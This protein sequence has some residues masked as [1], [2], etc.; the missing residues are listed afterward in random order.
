M[1]YKTE[2]EKFWAGEFGNE[3]AERNKA[4]QGVI[5]NIALF[6]E[7]LKRTS[8]IRTVLEFGPNIGRNIKALKTLFPDAK[9][10]AVEINHKAAEILR[11]DPVLA[12]M[13]V[14]ETSILDYE[15]DRQFDFVFT[16]GVLIHINPDELQC[17]Y[18]KLYDSSSKYICLVEYYNPS[19]VTVKYRENPER[20]FKRDFCGEFMDKFPDVRL[21]DY[22]FQYHRDNHFPQDDLTWF[23]L[24]K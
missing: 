17:V 1:N 20:L 18:Q 12:G 9:Y 2:Q 11:S 16:K 4:E 21:I 3:Y 22:G 8:A 15:A 10:S 24:E 6:A 13:E 7:I 19:P 23:L 5:C 14:F